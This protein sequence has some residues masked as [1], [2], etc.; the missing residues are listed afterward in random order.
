MAEPE[1]DPDVRVALP[2]DDAPPLTG[3]PWRR[4]KLVAWIAAGALL[5]GLAAAGAGVVGLMIDRAAASTVV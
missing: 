3:G 4:V 2:G 5:L 1:P